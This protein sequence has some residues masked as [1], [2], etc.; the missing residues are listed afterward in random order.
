V[1]NPLGLGAMNGRGTAVRLT[2]PAALITSA[3]DLSEARL[4]C[5][6]CLVTIADGGDG[7]VVWAHGG[8]ARPDG[9][10]C[11]RCADRDRREA[12]LLIVQYLHGVLA[13]AGPEAALAAL[14]ELG[15]LPAGIV[16][17]A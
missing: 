17:A 15:R 8:D 9:V 12:R 3:V 4:S 5:A 14:A 13:T 7:V 2:A 10:L 16:L 11:N 6:R 1:V